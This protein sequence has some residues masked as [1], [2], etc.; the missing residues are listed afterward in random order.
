MA[1]QVLQNAFVSIDGTDLSD[2][3]RSVT[4]NYSAEMQDQTAMGD[5]TRESIGGLKQ[6]SMDVEFNQD[7]AASEVDATMF[8]IVGTT[9]AIILRPDTGAVS[10]T[11]PQFTGN[12]VIE[13]YPPI[14]GAV[15]DVHTT[16]VTIQSA[17]TL[18]RAT[19]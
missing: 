2:H 16:S 3:V 11:N 7:Y 4:L 19:S 1:E 14:G 8:G 15:G 17:G 9:V 5:D 18:A 13:S 6:W 10:A 12:G